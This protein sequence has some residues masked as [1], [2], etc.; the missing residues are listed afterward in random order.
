MERWGGEEKAR[1]VEGRGEDEE[2]E[3]GGEETFLGVSLARGGEGREEVERVEEE[4]EK[5]E[6]VGEE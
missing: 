2:Q 4:E 3:E 6:E 5:E 1:R